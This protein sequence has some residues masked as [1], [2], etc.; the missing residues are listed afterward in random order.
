MH[1]KSTKGRDRKTEA[2]EVDHTEC[3][4]L[5]N[6]VETREKIYRTAALKVILAYH[7]ISGDAVSVI[8][9]CELAGF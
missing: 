6:R 4:A 9:G 8:N 2:L 1:I 5:H 7:T 3:L